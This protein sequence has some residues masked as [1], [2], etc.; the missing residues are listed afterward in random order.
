MIL[1]A[2]TW[3]LG[4]ELISLKS[5]QFLVQAWEALFCAQ[6]IA[7]CTK[8]VGCSDAV[9]FSKQ[10]SRRQHNNFRMSQKKNRV[11]F[12]H[13]LLFLKRWMQAFY[14]KLQSM[15]FKHY[16]YLYLN[17]SK[18]TNRFYKFYQTDRRG[19]SLFIPLDYEWILLNLLKS[20]HIFI[21]YHVTCHSFV[22][23]LSPPNKQ[24]CNMK[25]S[26]VS[27]NIFL[28]HAISTF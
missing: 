5:G 25:H 9:P 17:Q 15:T 4:W 7:H 2:W 3:P 14:Y 27:Q 13:C 19:S 22:L 23:G 8:Q 28:M 21:L 10:T 11:R 12:K 26:C 1:R 18:H 16:F 6:F 24:L 20:N